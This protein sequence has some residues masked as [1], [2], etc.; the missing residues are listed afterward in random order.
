VY[1][2]VKI[3]PRETRSWDTAVGNRAPLKTAHTPH[4]IVF[5]VRRSVVSNVGSLI[6]LCALRVATKDNTHPRTAS[7]LDTRCVT[8]EKRSCTS[9]VGP[10]S[11][12]VY[13]LTC[14]HSHS[15][16]AAGN[17]HGELPESLKSKETKAAPAKQETEGSRKSV[18]TGFHT[19]P[20]K[21]QA[22]PS[23]EQTDLGEGW[24]HVDRGGVYS[25]PPPLHSQ[26]QSSLVSRSW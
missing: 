10:P 5:V 17:P 1:F 6:V 9:L 26:V 19:A 23:A 7:A 4:F 20:K 22:G 3:L 8:E 24:N 14:R 13:G 15:T 16:V 2:L 18:A 12:P 25:R 21:E 11:F